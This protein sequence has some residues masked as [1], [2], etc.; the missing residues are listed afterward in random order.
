MYMCMCICNAYVYVYT[1]TYTKTDDDVSQSLFNLETSEKGPGV[2]SDL[3][4][5]SW[6]K[7]L[8]AMQ[9]QV[10]AGFTCYAKEGAGIEMR[11]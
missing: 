6:Q 8:S 1:H 9:R 11:V 5:H 10:M 7:S 3:E 2:P 4:I